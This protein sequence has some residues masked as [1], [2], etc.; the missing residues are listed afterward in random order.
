MINFAD[1]V[2]SLVP[3]LSVAPVVSSGQIVRVV[4]LTLEAK[5]I[6]APLG[7]YCQVENSDSGTFIDAEVVGFQADLLY[8]MPFTD[9]SGIGPGAKIWVRSKNSK[10]PIGRNML[11][12]VVDGLGR[13]I[14]GQG[15]IQ[16]DAHLS[17]EGEPINPMER[18]PIEKVLDTGIK[19]ID[20]CLT[21][22]QGQR[23]GLMA[24]SGVGKSVLLGMLTRNTEADV[25]VIGLIGERGREV[26]EFIHQTLGPNGLKKAIVVASPANESPVVR[27]KAAN[28]THLIAEY[29]RDQGKNVLMLCDSL[30]RVAHAQREI[31]LAIGEPPTAKGY[32]PSVFALL[33]KLIERAGV[34][35]NGLGSITAI[36]TVLAE[37]DDRSDP[38][39]DMARASL[40]GQVMLSRQLADA[41]HYPAIDLAGSIS[42]LMSNLL[43]PEQQTIA[44]RLR[45]LWTLYQQNKDLIQVGAYE[46]GSNSE[47]DSAINLRPQ[48]EALLQQSSDVAVTMRQSQ[49]LL[50][51]LME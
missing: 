20:T 18:G 47:L 28:L 41:A 38:V 42:R 2:A 39:I 48:I 29:F 37:G 35:R 51:Q 49:Q 8:L 31:G 17:L 13:P 19:A 1:H 44:N 34:G 33:P 46:P 30:T 26:Q 43:T 15:P 9:P 36:Y 3:Q 40:D 45:R 5:G 21:L 16:Y 10:M 7:A 6:A 12:R 11:G 32:P 23:I 25:V 24:G 22:G 14:D 27:L 50:Q 4:G